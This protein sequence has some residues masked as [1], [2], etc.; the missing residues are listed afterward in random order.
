MRTKGAGTVYWDESKGAWVGRVTL[1][2]GKRRSVSDKDKR[3]AEKKLAEMAKAIGSLAS[4]EDIGLTVSDL[5]NQYVERHLLVA[6]S[7]V[8]TKETKRWALEH[9]AQHI[10]RVRLADL[11][12]EQI[13]F[14]L[15]EC[16][17]GGLG[18][19]S[20]IKVHNAFSQVLAYGERRQAI[21]RNWAKVVDLPELEEEDDDERARA[22][23]H[24]ELATFL[25]ASAGTP[26]DSLWR[27]MVGTGLRPGEATG[28]L[29]ED[30]DLTA[31]RVHVRR[32]L[33]SRKGILTL[34]MKLK[35]EK[36]RRTVDL[37]EFA[38]LALLAHKARQN[39]TMMAHRDVWSN[40]FPGLVFTTSKGTPYSPANVRRGIDKVAAKAGIGDWNPNEL[41]HTFASHLC[42]AGVAAERVADILG[43]TDTRMVLKHYRHHIKPSHREGAA[44]MDTVFAS[45]N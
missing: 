6:K 29:W 41:R 45:I 2:N 5:I 11:R 39:E 38:R 14:A 30:I 12:P 4:P 22:M 40:E 16:R 28:L 20:L 44:V 33:T 37:P 34:T 8:S 23:T 13:E 3:R 9:I 24:E 19:A 42:E 43:H 21:E 15:T 1:P 10:G 31:G 35:T 32:Q 25:K 17:D 36:S 7:A 18:R 27:L 26:L